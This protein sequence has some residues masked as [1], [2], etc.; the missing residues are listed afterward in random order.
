MPTFAGCAGGPCC[1][2]SSH[3]WT[4]ASTPLFCG[5]N[6]GLGVWARGAEW[7]AKA[8]TRPSHPPA[9]SPVSGLLDSVLTPG[10]GGGGGESPPFCRALT[11][12]AASPCLIYLIYSIS[13]VFDHNNDSVI[14]PDEIKRTMHFLGESVTD[15]EVQAM[16]LEADT[17]QDGLVNFEEFKQMMQ[18]LRRPKK[19]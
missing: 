17:D 6:P 5:Q 1:R 12:C 14:D 11:S 10:P 4:T 9:A 18:L 16:L 2:H 7:S 15:E 19:R 8:K 3:N 13:Q